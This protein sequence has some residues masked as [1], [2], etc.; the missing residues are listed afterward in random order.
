MK[1]KLLARKIWSDRAAF[2]KLNTTTGDVSVYGV[3][4]SYRFLGRKSPMTGTLFTLSGDL[5]EEAKKSNLSA[6]K[7][8]ELSEIYRRIW[9]KAQKKDSWFDY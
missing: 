6:P 9:Q 2:M 8:P 5:L 3:D 4:Q 1:E 7:S